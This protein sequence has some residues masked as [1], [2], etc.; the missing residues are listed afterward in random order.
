MDLVENRIAFQED[1]KTMTMG[2]KGSR[3]ILRY[4]QD[5]YMARMIGRTL[6]ACRTL[7]EDVC[8]PLHP[9]P[10]HMQL[11]DYS[12]LQPRDMKSEGNGSGKEYH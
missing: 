7:L 12:S 6:R 11:I 4:R 8:F 10:F 3:G 2:P 9:F 5:D 1:R